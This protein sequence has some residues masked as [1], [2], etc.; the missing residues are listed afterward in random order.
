MLP[1]H[2]EKDSTAIH[3]C[4]GGQAEEGRVGALSPGGVGC[5]HI[6]DIR[7][8]GFRA[9]SS[10]SPAKAGS[11][12]DSYWNHLLFLRNLVFSLH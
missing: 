5:S 10:R 4:P 9:S 12:L 1:R 3:L 6:A 7:N 11:T 8:S 2:W